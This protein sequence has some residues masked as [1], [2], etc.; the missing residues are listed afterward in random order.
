MQ[1][2]AELPL[3]GLSEKALGERA[4]DFERT[5][6]A[7]TIDDGFWNTRLGGAETRT[8]VTQAEIPIL[9]TTGYNDFYVGGVMETWKNMRPKTKEKSALLLSPY[10]HG[11]GYSKENGLA[12]PLGAR[13]EAF[14]KDY[15]IAWFDH[16]RTGSH[17]PFQKGVITYF[18]AFEKGWATDFYQ[19]PT[20]PVSVP[21]GNGDRPFC[22]DPK[23][24]PKFLE[25]GRF[26]ENFDGRNDVVT[27]YTRPFEKDAFVKGKMQAVFS[28]R[29]DRPDTSFYVRIS[30]EKSEY[31]YVLRHDIT[32]LCHQLGSY[33]ENT[34]VPLEFTFDEYAFLIQKGERL[35]VDISATDDNTY[36]SHTNQ[37][38]EYPVQTQTEIARNT[39]FVEQSY[40]I[41]PVE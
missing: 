36:V 23:N 16:I 32:S 28:V 15:Q 7:P 5:L 39:V 35:R 19:T 13:K 2:F 37:K 4:E 26:A 41:L 29:S 12:F 38:G 3:Q 27:L 40:L 11:D 10:N 1:S 14:G 9:L 24:P 22:Y 8:A 31:A 6:F 21:L 18:R 20:N 25:E 30:L 33:K 34:V 17:L